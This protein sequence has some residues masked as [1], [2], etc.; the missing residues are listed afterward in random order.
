MS[1]D[2]KQGL[3]VRGIGGLYLVAVGDETIMI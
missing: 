2:N 3:V 1:E